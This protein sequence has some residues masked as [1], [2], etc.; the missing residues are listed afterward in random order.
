MI[1]DNGRQPP[2]GTKIQR[3]TAAKNCPVIENTYYSRAF[4]RKA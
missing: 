4:K 2:F 3:N 1:V